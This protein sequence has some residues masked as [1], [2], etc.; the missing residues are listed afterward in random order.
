MSDDPT[1]VLDSPYRYEVRLYR[2]DPSRR[3]VVW[4]AIVFAGGLGLMWTNS[5]LVALIGMLLVVGG[6]AEYVFP[7]RVT[8]D[9]ERAESRCFL[10]VTSIPWSEVRR[11]Q[12]DKE[13]VKLSPLKEPDWREPFRG[14]Y[15]RFEGNREELLRIIE[16]YRGDEGGLLE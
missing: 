10:S 4:A 15:L 16:A 2:R 1:E 14:V 5:P 13:G 3:F 9:R 6:V 12:A 8:V 11:V 7:I